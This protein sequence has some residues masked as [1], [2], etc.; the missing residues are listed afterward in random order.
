M[1]EHIGNKLPG[2]K[3]IGGKIIKSQVII[4]INAGLAVQQVRKNKNSN[5]NY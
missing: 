4:Y 5:I 3:V 2:L 1:Q